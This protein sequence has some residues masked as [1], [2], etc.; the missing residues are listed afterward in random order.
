MEYNEVKAES[1]K[2]IKL[3]RSNF[4]NERDTGR[5]KPRVYWQLYWINAKQIIRMYQQFG[6][7]DKLLVFY[8]FKLKP[9][10][11]II[12]SKFCENFLTFCKKKLAYSV[13]MCIEFK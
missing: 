12:L 11:I 4:K 3:F 13:N 2:H 1:N 5:I 7:L 9:K 6:G 8:Y 10:I